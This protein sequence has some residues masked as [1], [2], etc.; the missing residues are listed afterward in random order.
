M[1]IN[2]FIENSNGKS[3]NELEAMVLV[4]N[5]VPIQEK[6]M[7]CRDVLDRCVDDSDGYVTID[8]FDKTIYFTT[9]ILK[10]YTNIEFSEDYNSCIE[11]YDALC[12]DNWI[13]VLFV[14]IGDDIKRFEKVFKNEKSAMLERNSVEAQVAKVVNGLVGAIDALSGKLESS[15]DGANFNLPEGVDFTELMDLFKKYK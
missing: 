7:I 4:R 1:K 15:L 9:A 6:R 11:E 13:K 12:K 8:H 14:M 10:A 3:G 2:E 5:Y